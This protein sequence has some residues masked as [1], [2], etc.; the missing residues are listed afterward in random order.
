MF[1]T[2][3]DSVA[4]EKEFVKLED[5]LNQPE[6][7]NREQAQ[8]IVVK[9]LLGAS[10]T[11]EA[12]DFSTHYLTALKNA[13]EKR[14]IRQEKVFYKG[15]HLLKQV[16]AT[17]DEIITEMLNEL[18]P[19]ISH[20]DLYFATYEQKYISIYGKAQGERISPFEYIKRHQNGFAHACAWWH[21]RNY[22]KNETP[23]EYQ[24]DFFQSKSTP[25]WREL[26]TNKVTMKA[27]Y[28]GNECNALISFTDLLLKTIEVFHFGTI[29]YRSIAAPLHKRCKTY[30]LGT[31]I[32]SYNLAKYGWVIRY[33]VPDVP[34]EINLQPY[35]K[36][37]IY[38]IA[39]TPTL[40]RN[41][42]KPSFEWSRTYNSV[43]TKAITSQGCVKFLDFD[44]DMTFWDDSDYIIPWE[45]PDEEHVKLL[46]SM[47]FSKLPKTIQTSN[48]DN[49]T[50]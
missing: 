11:T 1:Y 18:E 31:K 3:F 24:L 39:W 47:G 13:L 29:D 27:Y 14:Q 41:T 21:W 25:A 38:F 37:P 33:T 20:I 28:S 9:A 26:E 8:P 34:L 32:K 4:I 50:I 36:H 42:V 6:V 2:G 23:Y 45:K 30:A 12:S 46:S 15:A 22:S 5:F 17:S 40:P 43:M 49:I 16:G 35:V 10:V 7:A 44:R 48:L 19:V